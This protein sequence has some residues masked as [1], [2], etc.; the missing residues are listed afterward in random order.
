MTNQAEAE[1][2]VCGE[3]VAIEPARTAHPHLRWV[4]TLRVDAVKAGSF[5]AKELSFAIHSPTKS[6]VSVSGK[7]V[8]HLIEESTDSFRVVKIGP[9]DGVA[10]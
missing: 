1:T 6:N 7:Y 5:D 10:D 4:V 9:W 3:V 2:I 8:V